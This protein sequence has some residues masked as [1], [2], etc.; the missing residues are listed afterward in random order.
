MPYTI[1]RL[2]KDEKFED[3]DQRTRQMLADHGFGVLTEIDVK[4]RRKEKAESER[5]RFMCQPG[6]PGK[7]PHRTQFQ[8]WCVRNRREPGYPQSSL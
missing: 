1:D 8:W 5:F 4:A 7:I 3:V 2:I 6:C